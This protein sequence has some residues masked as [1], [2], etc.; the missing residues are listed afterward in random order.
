MMATLFEAITA[1]PSILAA[2]IVAN[3]HR[4]IVA[5]AAR[6]GIKAEFSNEDFLYDCGRMEE[7]LRGEAKATGAVSFY[8]TSNFIK[9]EG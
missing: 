7:S 4:S 6:R 9:E 8:T 2:N 3:T 1:D 5:W